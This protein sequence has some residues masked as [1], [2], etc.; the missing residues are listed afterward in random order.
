M[1]SS[2]SR[3]QLTDTI[4]EVLIP[5]PTGPVI[6]ITPPEQPESPPVAPKADRGKGKVTDDVESPKKLVVQ[7][8][9]TKAGVDPTIFTSAKSGQEFKKIQDAEIKVLNR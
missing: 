3:I 6:D 1:I 4:L 8:E 5:Q 2:S 9:D 7:E